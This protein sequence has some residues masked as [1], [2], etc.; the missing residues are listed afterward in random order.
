ME[1][2]EAFDLAQLDLE[3]GLTI[4]NSPGHRGVIIQRLTSRLLARSAFSYSNTITVWSTLDDWLDNF[5]TP[6]H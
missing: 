6:F 3:I 5:R 2:K 4:L 1:I